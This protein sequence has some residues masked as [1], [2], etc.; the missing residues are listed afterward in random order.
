MT[1]EVLGIFKT[2]SDEIIPQAEVLRDLDAKIG[3][4]DLGITIT[5]GM[6]AVIAGIDDLAGTP[7]SNQLARSG[8]AF[9][10]A[11]AST[12]GV[13]FATAMMRGGAAVKDRED[14]GVADVVAIGR[15][16]MQGLMDRG[17]AKIGDKTLLDALAPAIDAFEEAQSA[18]KSLKESTDTAVAACEAGT[19]ATIEMQSKV[20][21]ASWLGERSIGVQDPGATAVMYMLQAAQSWVNANT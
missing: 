9:N 21:R 12:F 3:D 10:R 2:I 11:A 20:S 15:A 5:R 4:G 13:L 16:A 18:G 14:V 19:T 7:A 1:D 8:M 6:E 17:K